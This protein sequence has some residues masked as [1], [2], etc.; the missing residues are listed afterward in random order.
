MVFDEEPSISMPPPEKLSVIFIL[1]PITPKCHQGH[2][3]VAMSN[4]DKFH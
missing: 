1:E 3:N 2:V 4:R